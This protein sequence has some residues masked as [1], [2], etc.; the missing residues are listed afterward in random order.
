[1]RTTGL[2]LVEVIG[3]LMVR[4]PS[5]P[6][7]AKWP[8]PARFPMMVMGPAM[9][10]LPLAALFSK[11]PREPSPPPLKVMALEIVTPL[12]T[13]RRL[14]GFI[15]GDGAGAKGIVIGRSDD[16]A[17][18]D[19]PTGV[20]VVSGEGRVT[21]ARLGHG[22]CAAIVGDLRIQGEGAGGV[23][24]EEQFPAGRACGKRA[25]IRRGADGQALGACGGGQEDAVDPQGLTQC[26]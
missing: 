13:T 23:V 2:V 10:A 18:E 26:A 1:M 15:N 8:P 4:V 11:T 9:V 17:A 19:G 12:L 3:P 25:G 6:V 16:A 20:G 21:R 22:G 14:V 5:V 24:D 7:L